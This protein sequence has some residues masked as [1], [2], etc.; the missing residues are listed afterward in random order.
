MAMVLGMKVWYHE[1]VEVMPHPVL[2]GFTDHSAMT[3][4]GTTHVAA[5][6]GVHER[7]MG[8]PSRWPCVGARKDLFATCTILHQEAWHDVGDQSL[9]G[10][11]V[12]QIGRHSAQLVCGLRKLVIGLFVCGRNT[13]QCDTQKQL[14]ISQQICKYARSVLVGMK[15]PADA[16]RVNPPAKVAMNR[17]LTTH[18]SSRRLCESRPRRR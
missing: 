3:A 4:L 6:H 13:A 12:V 17:L 18:A 1:V 5:P 2:F 9:E 15:A 7:Q 16:G 8:R 14:T 11:F 10:F